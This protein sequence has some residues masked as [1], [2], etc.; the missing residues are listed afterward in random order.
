MLYRNCVEVHD[1]STAHAG[2]NYKSNLLRF[3]DAT[4][5]TTR[6]NSFSNGGA[7]V[8]GLWF[9]DTGAPYMP[10]DKREPRAYC[11]NGR[12]TFA[13][14]GTALLA[15]VMVD[16]GFGVASVKIDGVPP[17]GILGVSEALDT[18]S[19]DAAYYME[20]S[21]ACRTVLL[22][23]GL[24]PGSHICELTIVDP[25]DRKYWVLNGF[26]V[27]DGTLKALD[28]TEW[29]LP[30]AQTQALGVPARE[31]RFSYG[32]DTPLYNLSITMP[33]DMVGSSGTYQLPVINPPWS[34]DRPLRFPTTGNEGPGPWRKSIQLS[35]EFVDPN[36]NIE[37]VVSTALAANSAFLTFTG[38]G[39][40]TDTLPGVPRVFSDN[41][42]DTLNFRVYAR[43]VV[44]RVQRDYGWGAFQV[45]RGGAVVTTISCNDPVGQQMF[46]Y[47]VDLGVDPP[48]DGSGIEVTLRVLT[49][50]LPAVFVSCTFAETKRFTARS[51]SVLLVGNKTYPAP[52]KMANP[53]LAPGTGDIIA[54]PPDVTAAVYEDGA[55][56][57]NYGLNAVETFERTPTYAVCYQPG[58]SDMLS[59]YDILIVDPFGARTPDIERWKAL[60]IKVY[61]YISFGEEDSVER[62]NPYAF[63]S[64]TIPTIGDGL[65]PNGSASYFKDKGDGSREY[66]E[67]E[68]DNQCTLGTKTCAQ[69][70]PNYFP[71]T[72]TGAAN[73]TARCSQRCTRDSGYTLWLDGG[74]CAGGFSKANN[75]RRDGIAACVN[76]ACPQYL[77]AH[78][79]ATGAPCPNFTRLSGWLGD[80]GSG[81]DANGIWGSYYI[82]PNA[83]W[84]ARLQ[85]LYLPL[86]LGNAVHHEAEAV[87]VENCVSDA[88]PTTGF[89]VA[90]LPIDDDKELIVA[91]G[92]A[93]L[94]QYVDYSYDTRTG[95]FVLAPS[96][97]IAAGTIL[98]VSYWR[99]GNNMDGVFMDTVDTVDVYPNPDYQQRF[100]DRIN[101]CKV[102]Y[103]DK[104]FISNRGFTILDKIIASCSGVMFETFLTSYDW[105]T[106]T[107]FKVTGEAK[108]WND[109]I[110]AQLRALRRNHVFDVFALNYCQD[111]ASGDELRQYIAEESRKEGYLSW[112]TT[113]LLNNPQPSSLTDPLQS[114]TARTPIRDTVWRRSR[115]RPL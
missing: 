66:N 97:G 72:P 64:G 37:R 36:G 92:A 112:S 87:T 54:N 107:Y 30:Y 13:F 24:Q 40:S 47:T 91:N 4:N 31:L 45:E 41:A 106:N 5:H 114:P 15:R 58:F 17:S 12:L 34:F 93:V 43:S 1:L 102:A 28:R 26:L 53:R 71:T 76:S 48:A 104:Q 110:K 57:A 44:I 115:V 29:L 38:T 27:F 75:W 113:I 16:W 18:L 98:S 68:H 85:S 6:L 84:M 32:G 74:N 60:G 35:Y 96:L 19:C 23:D 82:D 81:P 100:A 9:T 3:F 95:Y 70:R 108:A 80:G 111:D 83:A 25:T 79:I 10:K 14:T 55:V 56:R 62:A 63:T 77:P 22:A 99:K 7:A 2:T 105:E 39:W 90:H 73:P 11:T 86:V 33:P 51:T 89:H 69:A 101:A 109:D 61:G 8:N 42:E 67:C 46:D 88:G 52:L 21:A 78:A 50:G 103:P 59:G 49:E 20:E 65:G 94:T